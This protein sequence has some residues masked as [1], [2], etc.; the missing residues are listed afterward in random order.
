M[1]SEEI[2][3]FLTHLAVDDQVTASTQNQALSAL[4][5]LYR[6]V[7][8]QELDLPV[9]AV[10]ARSR[11][12]P[13]VLTKEEVLGMIQHLSGGYQLVIQMLYGSG[14]RLTKGL[15]L[16]VKDL[17]FAQQQIVVRTKGQESQVT[18]L[19]TRLTE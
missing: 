8:R 1:S 9:D 13:T 5:F 17:D 7:L 12:L 14:L 15:Q 3:V 16:R 18:M 11:Y 2:E 4:L 6:E 10:R 19:P